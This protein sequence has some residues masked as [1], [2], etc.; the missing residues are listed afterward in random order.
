[1]I[2]EYVYI[3][4]VSLNSLHSVFGSHRKKAKQDSRAMVMILCYKF[5]LTFG[6]SN[7]NCLAILVHIASTSNS[8]LMVSGAMVASKQKCVHSVRSGGSF[9]ILLDSSIDKR[10]RPHH[11]IKFRPMSSTKPRPPITAWL[12]EWTQY[13]RA[14]VT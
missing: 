7:L 11:T 8:I 2:V 1:M 9:L 10:S 12:I 6:I 4:P 13:Q 5:D 14:F 3:W